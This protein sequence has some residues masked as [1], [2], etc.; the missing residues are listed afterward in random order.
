MKMRLESLMHAARQRYGA[1]A[2]I[3]ILFAALCT[4]SVFSARDAREAAADPAKAESDSSVYY[5]PN[6]AAS[7]ETDRESA[8]NSANFKEYETFFTV[9]A[10]NGSVAVFKD[11]NDVPLYCIETPLSSLTEED[12]RLLARGI[13]CRRFVSQLYAAWQKSPLSRGKVRRFLAQYDIDVS[14]CTQQT[15]RCFNDFFTRQRVRTNDRAA[16]DELPA[17]AD[18][19][20]T[21]LPIGED[22][23]FT[24]K[25]VSYRLGE[26]L[27]DDALAERFLGGWCLIFR[28][29]P[30]DYHRYAY[31]DTGTQEPTVRIPGVLHSVN[32][33]AGSLGVY[34]R[35]ARARTLLH[36]ERFGDIVQMEVGAMLVGRICNHETGAAACARLQEKGYFEYGGSTVILLLEHG[37][38]EPAADI[39]K[40]SARGIESKVKTGDPVGRRP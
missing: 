22:S 16:P 33:I 12:R 1:W 3:F 11:G 39:A 21:A 31:P 28:L 4:L 19:K 17:I 6:D 8:A 38:F 9:R 24:V 25:D 20:L 7:Q 14:D 29:S 30:D 23:V 18:S 36:T 2:A 5:S 32:P 26:L 37:K 10:Y 35:N 13:L 34:R 40:W 15:F 27:A